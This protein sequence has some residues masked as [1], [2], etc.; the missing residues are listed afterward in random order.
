MTLCTRTASV[1]FDGASR[2]T[3]DGTNYLDG[4]ALFTKPGVFLYFDSKTGKTRRE[5]R[6]PEDVFDPAS[7]ASAKNRPFT[8][9]HPPV[10]LNAQNTRQHQTG[11]FYGEVEKIDSYLASSLLITDEQTILDYENGK[12]DVSMG[13]RCKLDEKPGVHPVYGPY[14]AK[15]TMIRYNHCS[16]VRRGRMGPDCAVR[17]DDLELP[18]EDE[19]FDA[20]ELPEQ[21]QQ[22]KVK[23]MAE[24]KLDE[25]TRLDT[26]DDSL[27]AAVNARIQTLTKENKELTTKLDTAEGERDQHKQNAAQLKEKVDTFENTDIKALAKEWAQTETKALAFLPKDFK[28]DEAKSPVDIMRAALAAADKET[29]FTNKSDEYIKGRFDSLSVPA[30]KPN[31]PSAAFQAGVTNKMTPPAAGQGNQQRN[32]GAGNGNRS[33]QAEDEGLAAYRSMY[34]GIQPAG[35]K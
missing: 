32:D 6:A 2:R 14:D 18:A 27:A 33:D 9:N 19:R 5:L 23:K 13:Y 15:Q 7:I 11:Y 10:M 30:A 21:P 20:Y 34:P 31:Q 12:R 8:N 29:D 1:R 28:M 16:L 3:D 24:I 35:G 4:R 17:A 26:E 25:A 22:R